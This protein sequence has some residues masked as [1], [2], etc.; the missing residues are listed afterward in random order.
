MKKALAL[1]SPALS[2]S[3]WAM[4][5]LLPL[6][7]PC[8]AAEDGAGASPA[9]KAPEPEAAAVRVEVRVT[10]KLVKN[11]KDEE[12]VVLLVEIENTGREAVELPEY[13]GQPTVEV[14]L[15]TALGQ[16][17]KLR[18][19]GDAEWRRAQAFVAIP[20]AVLGP[21]QKRTMTLVLKDLKSE[22]ESNDALAKD[23]LKTVN[24]LRSCNGHVVVEYT[25]GERDFTGTLV[26]GA[27]RCDRNEEERKKKEQQ[28]K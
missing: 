1:L 16:G 25:R 26:E 21:K 18:L 12:T 5:L 9:A 20:R 28:Q 13:E 17:V 8:G 23:V 7:G 6:A 15:W 3:S 4:I 11:P 22:S 24:F 2:L 27:F 19:P 10:P 14:E